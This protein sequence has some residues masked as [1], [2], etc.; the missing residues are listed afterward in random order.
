MIKRLKERYDILK[1]ELEK[2]PFITHHTPT[3]NEMLGICECLFSLADK[4]D[5]LEKKVGGW[6][7]IRYGRDE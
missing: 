2:G 6:G 7:Q 4:V 1:K 5:V 3:V